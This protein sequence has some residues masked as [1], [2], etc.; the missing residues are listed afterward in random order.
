[1]CAIT[2]DSH[3]TSNNGIGNNNNTN[4]WHFDAPH[5]LDLT[6]IISFKVCNYSVRQVCHNS[7]FT[8]RKLMHGEIIQSI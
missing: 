1:V 8:M 6:L 2:T 3:H 5:V 7:Q 4:K